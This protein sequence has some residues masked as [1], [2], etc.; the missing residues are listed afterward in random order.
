MQR[1]GR[2]TD[3]QYHGMVPDDKKPLLV[4]LFPRPKCIVTSAVAI[5][6]YVEHGAFVAALLG[7]TVGGG[8]PGEGPRVQDGDSSS[9]HTHTPPVTAA[10]LQ[11]LYL[12]QPRLTPVLTMPPSSLTPSHVSTPPPGSSKYFPSLLFEA[13]MGH[14]TS[15]TN[16]AGLPTGGLVREDG[17][18]SDS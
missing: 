4:Q 15:C 3:D 9:L 13:S 10:A 6:F 8:C 14:G 16:H 11:I 17:N 18:E 7:D 12:H 2:G 1:G 5:F